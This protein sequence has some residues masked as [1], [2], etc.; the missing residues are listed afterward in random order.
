MGDKTTLPSSAPTAEKAAVM[1]VYEN[2][3]QALAD[4]G[5]GPRAAITIGQ[6]GGIFGPETIIH[7]SNLTGD[8]TA[9]YGLITVDGGK[10]TNQGWLLARSIDE[11]PANLNVFLRSASFIN[12]GIVEADGTEAILTIYGGGQTNRT[13]SIVNNDTIIAQHGGFVILGEDISGTGLIEASSGG[14]VYLNGDV[15][16]GQTIE[17]TSATLEFPGLTGGGDMTTERWMANPGMNFLGTLDLEHSARIQLNGSWKIPEAPHRLEL[18]DLGDG[19]FELRAFAGPMQVFEAKLLNDEPHSLAQ[20]QLTREG[21][22]M[23]IDYSTNSLFPL[24]A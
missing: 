4:P 22:S 23:V 11:G 18:V 15:A 12:E 8:T 2:F 5:R 14:K 19:G 1:K 13:D 10:V 6:E 20:F 7:T 21:T 16:A 24:P 9:R 3:K 17:I